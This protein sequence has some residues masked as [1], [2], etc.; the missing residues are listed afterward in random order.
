MERVREGA[1]RIDVSVRYGSSWGQNSGLGVALLWEI[2][3]FQL[4]GKPVEVRKN[5][6]N[7]DNWSG[8]YEGE[9]TPGEH[10]L[11]ALVEYAYVDPSKLI[12]LDGAQ[13]SVGR[14]PKSRKRG[15]KTASIAFKTYAADAVIVKTTTETGVGLTENPNRAR[16]IAPSLAVISISESAGSRIAN[17]G[18]AQSNKRPTP[19]NRRFI[20]DHDVPL[21]AIQVKLMIKARCSAA[22]AWKLTI[23]PSTAYSIKMAF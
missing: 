1:K 15:T 6:K 17:R 22:K 19:I 13:L 10:Q 7:Q 18:K 8:V 20:L 5:Y 21:V 14:W 16:R 2:K 3:Q 11:T 12:G 9:L 4:D 23:R